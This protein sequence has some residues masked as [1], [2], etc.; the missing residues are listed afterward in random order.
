MPRLDSATSWIEGFQAKS[1]I[2]RDRRQPS[3][4]TDHVGL[5][6]TAISGT[7]DRDAVS[8]SDID[9]IVGCE[10]SRSGDSG[11]GGAVGPVAAVTR[12]P[13]SDVEGSK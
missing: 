3:L 9:R 13:A 6:E 8:C 1:A 10:S 12:V 11:G 4:Q 7:G 2:E 5:P